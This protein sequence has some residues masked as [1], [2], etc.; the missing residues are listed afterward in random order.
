MNVDSI[1]MVYKFL[2]VKDIVNASHTCRKW[3]RVADGDVVSRLKYPIIPL[4]VKTGLV[5]PTKGRGFDHDIIVFYPYK[6][7]DISAH[8]I[9]KKHFPQY[10]KLSG[11]LVKNSRLIDDFVYPE[12]YARAALQSYIDQPIRVYNPPRPDLVS[13][14]KGSKLI[15]TKFI[16]DGNLGKDNFFYGYGFIE[17]FRNTP[18][19]ARF[20]PL[21]AKLL[22]M[23]LESQIT[24]EVLFRSYKDPHYWSDVRHFYS[25]YPE[26]VNWKDNS[27]DD[28]HGGGTYNPYRAKVF[29]EKFIMA[30]EHLWHMWD[31]GKIFDCV[32]LNI[33]TKKKIQRKMDM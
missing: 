1:V 25:E 32:D 23:T 13:S 12:L 17:I 30:H 9:W 20:I 31:W 5:M 4:Q 18:R 7:S 14:I 33:W 24:D 6:A 22:G 29:D 26:L 10:P 28:P 2:T 3:K 15:A 27:H 19:K 21:F 16:Q 11:S 8:H